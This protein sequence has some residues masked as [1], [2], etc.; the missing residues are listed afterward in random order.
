MLCSLNIG[1]CL[2]IELYQIQQRFVLYSFIKFL[3]FLTESAKFDIFLL[4]EEGS[5]VKFVFLGS[6]SKIYTKMRVFP[7]YTMDSS[8]VIAIIMIM[9]SQTLI[10]L[11]FL[12]FYEVDICKNPLTLAGQATT[13]SAGPLR[14]TE[15]SLLLKSVHS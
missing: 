7:G 12:V 3:W 1:T 5:D 14:D 9:Y 4:I 6:E 8:L 15:E 13:I 11:I 10:Q 2:K